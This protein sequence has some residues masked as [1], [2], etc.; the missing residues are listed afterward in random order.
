MKRRWFPLLATISCALIAMPAQTARR[1]RYGGVLRVEIAE[2][3]SSIE[4]P[5][6]TAP[7]TSSAIEQLQSLLYIPGKGRDGATLSVQGPFRI[8]EWEPSKH[9]HLAAN[10][11][12][13][14]GRPFVDFVDVQMGRGDKDRLLDLELGKADVAPIP[15]GEARRAAERG[16]RL[17]VSRPDELIALVFVAGRPAA[18]NAAIRQSLTQAIDRPS[19]ASFIL[20]KEGESAGGLLPQWSSGTAFLFAVTSDPGARN[21]HGA[22][23]AGLPKI[24]L[25]YDAGDALEQAIAERVAVNARE[26]GIVV[27]SIP[28]SNGRANESIGVRLVRLRMTSSK[29]REALAGFLAALG[30]LAGINVNLPTDAASPEAIYECQRLVMDTYRVIPLVWIPQVYGLSPR[31]RNWKAPEPGEVWPLADL[32]LDDS[33][34]NAASRVG[35]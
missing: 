19:I 6:A 31:V 30:P 14:G 26:S 23:I 15:A 11:G 12:F 18:E 25:G 7:K 13:S 22:K 34:A 1:P 29:P 35:K 5:N 4:P 3:T 33:S 2:T 20:Q 9:A 17:S 24:S 27:T 21:E 16:V 28:I 8:V 32:W 10:D